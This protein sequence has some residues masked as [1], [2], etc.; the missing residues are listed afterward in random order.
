MEGKTKPWSA[1]SPGP[2]D[3]PAKVTGQ[4]Q[5]NSILDQKRDRQTPPPSVIKATTRITAT[6]QQQSED[7]VPQREPHKEQ[8]QAE[9][10]PFSCCGGAVLAL[11]CVTPALGPALHPRVGPVPGARRPEGNAPTRLPFAVPSTHLKLLRSPAPKR[12][13]LVSPVTRGNQ[14]LNKFSQRCR[15]LF[16]GSPHPTSLPHCGAS[17]LIPRNNSSPAA[18]CNKERII[19][20]NIS[21]CY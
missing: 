17:R 16:P 11:P 12:V 10:T 8:A 3:A 6:P 15:R 13:Q 7:T 20:I 5:R 14:T 4:T 2:D 18:K 1:A 19:S 21:Y 9:A